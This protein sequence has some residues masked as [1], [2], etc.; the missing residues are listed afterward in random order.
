VQGATTPEVLYQEF[1]HCEDLGVQLKP[2]IERFQASEA[3][4]TNKPSPTAKIDPPVRQNNS[5][6]LSKPLK[7]A[8]AVAQASGRTSVCR[9]LAC[10]YPDTFA[11]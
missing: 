5:I 9:S 7:L 6:V 2:V 4:K 10:S 1:F 8:D 3:H 11:S